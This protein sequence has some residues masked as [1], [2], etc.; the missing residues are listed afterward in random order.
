MR[1][2]ER[3]RARRERLAELGWGSPE[4]A[5]TVEWQRRCAEAMGHHLI[6]S[7]VDQFAD[8]APPRASGFA[9]LV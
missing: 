9:V 8:V 4:S 1:V 5:V 6:D 3:V 7:A 2:R